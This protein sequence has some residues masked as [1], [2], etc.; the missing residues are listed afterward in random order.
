MD[1]IV[2]SAL[3]LKREMINIKS[4]VTEFVYK[5]DRRKRKDYLNRV[6]NTMIKVF[7]KEERL[8]KIK[9]EILE[10]KKVEDKELDMKK[11][12]KTLGFIKDHRRISREDISECKKKNPKF[13][14]FSNYLVTKKDLGDFLI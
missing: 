2:R 14:M 7:N 1:F 5:F 10:Y 13:K 8:V 4:G 12:L 11:E 6:L 9:M 3:K